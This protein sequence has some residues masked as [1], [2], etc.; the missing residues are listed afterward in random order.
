MTKLSHRQP[1]LVGRETSIS[2]KREM[3]F[4]T[5][6]ILLIEYNGR[7]ESSRDSIEL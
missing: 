3:N 7:I 4:D 5:V 6:A 2:I 1:L